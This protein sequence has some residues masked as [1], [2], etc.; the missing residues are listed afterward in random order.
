MNAYVGCE[1]TSD[2]AT[3]PHGDGCSYYNDHPYDCG[4]YDTSAFDSIEMCCGC[5]GGGESNMDG[6]EWVGEYWVSIEL[7]MS[8]HWV[9]I[10]RLL[11]GY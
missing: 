6:T 9:G 5:D 11:G 10:E 3:D 2:G 1:D 8:E 7:G 4:M